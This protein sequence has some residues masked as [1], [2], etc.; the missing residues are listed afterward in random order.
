MHQ[1]ELIDVARLRKLRQYHLEATL[2]IRD[3]Q[4]VSIWQYPYNKRYYTEKN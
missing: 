3:Q 1:Q 2:A 4:I